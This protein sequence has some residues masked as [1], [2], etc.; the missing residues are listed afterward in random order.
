MIVA[1]EGPDKT[2]K[3]TSAMQSGDYMRDAVKNHYDT[4]VLTQSHTKGVVTAYDRIDWLTH[5]VYRLALPEYE[6]DDK[7]IRTVFA[8]PEMHLVFKLHLP[9][10][11]IGDELYNLEQSRRV[12]DMYIRTAVNL[13][14]TNRDTD[15][16]LFKTISIVYVKP[17]SGYKLLLAGFSSPVTELN[18]EESIAVNTNE[19]LL[20]LLLKEEAARV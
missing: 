18:H 17:A 4:E 12:N 11:E 5:M 14:Q 9:G 1:F 3:T 20:E 16:S 13:I 2:G 10:Y 6:W 8:A 15:F 19:K 7:R